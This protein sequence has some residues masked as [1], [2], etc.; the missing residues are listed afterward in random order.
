MS[1]VYERIGEQIWPLPAQAFF[2]EQRAP[3]MWFGDELPP[4][5]QDF[6]NRPDVQ[7]SQMVS[8]YRMLQQMAQSDAQHQAQAERAAQL[9]KRMRRRQRGR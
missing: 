7:Q 1:T 5:Y 9:A 8:T 4:T 6:L 2:T 3:D